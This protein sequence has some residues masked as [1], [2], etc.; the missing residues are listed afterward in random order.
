MYGFDFIVSFSVLCVSSD[1]LEEDHDKRLLI[2]H[3]TYIRILSLEGHTQE[4]NNIELEERQEPSREC[5]TVTIH[6]PDPMPPYE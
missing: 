4:N 6:N 1:P 3:L 5:N 2:P